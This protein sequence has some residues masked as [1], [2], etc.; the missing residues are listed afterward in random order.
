MDSVLIVEDIPE[1]LEFLEKVVRDVFDS[2]TIHTAMSVSAAH[3]LVKDVEFDLALID[4]SLPDGEGYSVFRELSS[5]QPG[6]IMVAATV[7][8][9][10]G[11]IV[12]ALSA[13]AQG[14]I[15]KSDPVALL[16]QSLNNIRDGMPPLSP[17][18]AR[19]V[20]EHFRFTGPVTDSAGTLTKRETEVLSYIAKGL[21][22]SDTANALEIAPST[23]SSH[24]K[25]I[26]EKLGVNS[27][28]EATT[29]AT[30]MG[31]LR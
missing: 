26:Y 16:K 20:M 9:S 13:G 18:V 29:E 2:V 1:T 5:K 24:I 19:R 30:R 8:G 7:M 27:R 17:A 14:Y 21:R 10:D 3:K 11:A 31:L 28:A 4:L 25:A 6:A 23:V 12:S 22:V 15:L